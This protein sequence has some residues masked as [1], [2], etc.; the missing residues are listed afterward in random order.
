MQPETTLSKGS[1]MI[2]LKEMVNS[3]LKVLICM[4]RLDDFSRDWSRK[5]QLSFRIKN[6]PCIIWTIEK[7]RVVN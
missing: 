7:V 6:I 3:S 5:I 2:I 4:M 1:G